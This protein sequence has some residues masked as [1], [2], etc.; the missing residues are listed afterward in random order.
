MSNDVQ[1][2]VAN[3]INFLSEDIIHSL[4]GWKYILDVLSL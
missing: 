2:K 4:T 3:L 1:D